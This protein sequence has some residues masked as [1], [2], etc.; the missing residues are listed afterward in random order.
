MNNVCTLVFFLIF[1]I[2]TSIKR[3]KETLKYGWVVSRPDSIVI[4][5]PYYL[6]HLGTLELVNRHLKVSN[7]NQSILNSDNVIHRSL[8]SA[9]SKSVVPY[10]VWF[11][12]ALNFPD[13]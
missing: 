8:D 11:H 10:L 6:D 3:K 4:Q 13:F 7:G 9:V 1:E 2:L 12:Y 5:T